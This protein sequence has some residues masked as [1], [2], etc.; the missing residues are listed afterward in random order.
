[1]LDGCGGVTGTGWEACLLDFLEAGVVTCLD[2]GTGAGAFPSS[3]FSSTGFRGGGSLL[4]FLGAGSSLADGAGFCP[5]STT[6]FPTLLSLL[7]FFSL[8]LDFFSFFFTA[9]GEKAKMIYL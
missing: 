1:M 6:L 9:R 5:E 8:V 3:L 7:S 4:L 2:S